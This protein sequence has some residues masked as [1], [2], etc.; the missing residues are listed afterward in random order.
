MNIRFLCDENLQDES[1]GELEKKLYFNDEHICPKCHRCMC[2]NLLRLSINDS[3][4]TDFNCCLLGNY[5]SD[6]LVTKITT[7]LI[8]VLITTNFLFIFFTLIFTNRNWLK[9]FLNYFT[10][11]LCFS[12]S[13]NL[14]KP[15]AENNYSCKMLKIL[16]PKS[17]Y[18]IFPIQWVT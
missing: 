8:H 11:S 14:L 15:L 17:R 9:N 13:N 12:P 2:W 3:L 1:T 18:N 5:I 16:Q 10:V 6:F 7:K 4:I